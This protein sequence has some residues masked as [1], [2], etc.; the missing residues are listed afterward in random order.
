MKQSIQLAKVFSCNDNWWEIDSNA[1]KETAIVFPNDILNL[2]HFSMAEIWPEVMDAERIEITAAK[3]KS[4][5][6]CLVGDVSVEMIDSGLHV[7]GM[8]IT[9]GPNTEETINRLLGRFCWS[10]SC[11]VLERK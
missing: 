1:S 5:D 4:P 11:R 6:A 8:P 3:I 9:I 10:V 7:N 2:C